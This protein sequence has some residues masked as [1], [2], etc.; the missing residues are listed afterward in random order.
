[1]GKEKKEKETII[2]LFFLK[3]K[4]GIKAKEHNNF[5]IGV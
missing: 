2:G 5:I 1:M 3:W 4:W